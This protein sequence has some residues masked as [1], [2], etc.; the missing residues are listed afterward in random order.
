MVLPT[1][2]NPTREIIYPISDGHAWTYFTPR[3][4]LSVTPAGLGGTCE[5]A[6]RPHTETGQ[7]RRTRLSVKSAGVRSGPMGM[8]KTLLVT[9]FCATITCFGQSAVVVNRYDQAA[10]GAN[11]SEHVLTTSNVNSSSF[12]K[13]YSYYV[14]GAVYAQPLYVPNV[15][16][17]GRGTQNVLYLVT[18][19]DKAYAFDADRPGAPL[20]V[21]DFTDE[22]AGVTPVPIT[23]ITNSNDLNLV[24]TIGIES[25]PAIDLKKK[26]MFLVVRT[27]GQG[28]YAQRLHRLDIRT[29]ADAAAP[30]LIEASVAGRAADAVNG[31]VHFDPKAGHQRAALALSGDNVVIAWASHEDLRP[32]HGWL[33]AYDTGTLRQT[34]A[35]CLTPDGVDGGIWQSGRGPVVDSEGALYYEVGNGSWDG[36]RDFGNSVIK[37]KLGLKGLCVLDSYTP[38]D[39]QH[40]NET[41]ADLGSTGPLSVPGTQAIVCGNKQGQLLILRK[42]RLGGMTGGDNGIQASFDLRGGRVLAGPALWNS[43]DAPTLYLWNESTCLRS[44]RIDPATP[45]ITPQREATVFSHGSPGGAL[46][47]S[48]NGKDPRTAIVWATVE[49]GRSADH[50]NATGVLYAFRADTLQQLWSSEAEPKRDRLGTLVKFVPPLVVAGKVYV[51]SYD[52]AVHVYGLLSPN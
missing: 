8:H 47:L 11:E 26:A 19:D 51:P 49:T 7:W 9:A 50:G 2:T 24:G 23:D 52:N 12:G 34:G 25:T 17:P 16:I 32:Y 42:D 1:A 38:H 5:T 21:R 22:S 33:I 30:V 6:G 15:A 43:S 37:V 44:F 18:M 36:R 3:P 4:L 48:S 35:L 40:Q 39:Y 29:G 28:R 14:A 45:S 13:L 46:T 31:M 27:K 41:D 20:W 10:T